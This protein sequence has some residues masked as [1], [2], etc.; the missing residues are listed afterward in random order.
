MSLTPHLPAAAKMDTVPQYKKFVDIPP[1]DLA[2]Q[3][4]LLEQEDFAKITIAEYSHLNFSK[5]DK[6][7][8]APHVINIINRFNKMS[9]WTATHIVLALGTD[10]SPKS[11]SLIIT[12][13][14]STMEHLLAL[15]NYSTTLQLFSAL[16]MS[17][18]SRLT[19]SWNLV[20]AK[21]KIALEEVNKVFFSGGPN[22]KVYREQLEF[23]E[24]PCIPLQDVFCRDLTFIEEN[25]TILENGWINFEKMLLLGKST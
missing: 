21:S 18:I 5:K 3:L 12:H 7:K 9:Y 20:T 13:I 24:A 16:N 15:K 14:I 1:E 17:C 22:N 19:K 23:V 2:K 25:P 10:S 8:K 11:R 6:E 4:T